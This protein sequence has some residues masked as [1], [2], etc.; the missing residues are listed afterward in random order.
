MG[1]IYI[2]QTRPITDLDIHTVE[3]IMHEFDSP[4]M[5]DTE[6][7][8]PLNVQE[9]IPG[10]VTPL[11]ADILLPAVDRSVKYYAYSRLGMQFPTHV[12]KLI[13]SFAGIGVFDVTGLSASVIKVLAGETG[14][15]GV[16]MSILDMAVEEHTHEVIH[17]FYGRN[18]SLVRKLKNTANDFFFLSRHDS[19]LYERLKQENK[20]LFLGEDATT[21]KALYKAIDDK[22]LFS[23]DMWRATLSVAA[24][25][26]I[27]WYFER[28]Q[29]RN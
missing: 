27:D 16:E 25:F 15:S 19:A 18:R 4:V 26:S 10:A 24:N 6:L 28:I 17:D 8:T 22:L 20:T 7:I 12:S 21:A 5:G 14:K 2:L 29:S 3:E 11:T 13:L 9:A 1:K 23:S